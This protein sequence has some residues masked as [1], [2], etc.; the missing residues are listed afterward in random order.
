MIWIIK[1]QPNKKLL[2]LR[3]KRLSK[4]DNQSFTLFEFLF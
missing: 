1:V 3:N 4:Y 2:I